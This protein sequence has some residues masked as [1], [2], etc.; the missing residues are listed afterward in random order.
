MYT[1]LYPPTDWVIFL[2]TAQN[3]AYWDEYYSSERSLSETYF[4]DVATKHDISI[5]KIPTL[6]LPLQ[7]TFFI[8]CYCNVSL[9][10]QFPLGESARDT[11][12]VHRIV[13]SVEEKVKGKLCPSGVYSC[14]WEKNEKYQIIVQ[15]TVHEVV[16][17]WTTVTRKVTWI[18]GG[19]CGW[20]LS[21]MDGWM[22][23][24]MGRPRGSPKDFRKWGWEVGRSGWETWSV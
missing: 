18:Q 9:S 21:S 6:V 20:G 3:R 23:G 22:D 17:Q 13:F 8:S 4:T 11:N 1:C 19:V 10:T 12:R 7:P 2:Q 24:Q 16:R 14:T 5:Q 15:R